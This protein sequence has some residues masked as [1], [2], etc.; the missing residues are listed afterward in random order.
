M[1]A[2]IGA[3]DRNYDLAPLLSLFCSENRV[4]EGRKID[5]KV[6]CDASE[7]SEGRLFPS[8]DLEWQST[9]TAAHFNMSQTDYSTATD[10][11]R[12]ISEDSYLHPFE[13]VLKRRYVAHHALSADC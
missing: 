8:L 11:T 10:G 12:V 9:R 5:P 3:F 1:R 7:E 6:V 13:G 4:K 2:N